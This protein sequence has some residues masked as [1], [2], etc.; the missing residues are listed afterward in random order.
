MFFQKNYG[1]RWFLTV[2]FRLGKT[3]FAKQ[4][5]YMV[6]YGLIK[7]FW[8]NCVNSPKSVAL[9]KFFYYLCNREKSTKE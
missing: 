3:C 2:D 7:Y 1:I 5:K 9:Y 4:P 8:L 6:N